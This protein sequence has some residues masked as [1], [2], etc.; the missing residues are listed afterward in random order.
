LN[1]AAVDAGYSYHTA[2]D[3]PERLTSAA[4]RTTGE[5]VV[6]I[7]TTL[8]RRD[9]TQRTRWGA[10]YFDVGG[11]SALSYGMI[12]SWIIAAVALM[13]G[14]V[15][16]LR[17]TSA[18]L[19]LSGTLRWIAAALWS[20]IGTAA[21]VASMVGTTWALRAGREVPPVVRAP[22][23]VVPVARGRRRDNRMGN[24]ARRR[25]AADGRA[26]PRHPVVIWS[27]ALPI[28]LVLAGAST[29]FTPAAAYL[30]TLPLLTAAILLVVAPLE[31]APVIRIASIVILAVAGTLWLR[32]TVDLLRFATAVLGRLPIVT[33]VYAYAAMMACAGLMVVPPLLAVTTREQPVS[34]PA[35]VTSV[36]L[37]ALAIAAGAA[38][39]AP[40]Y[41]SEY[42]AAA[43]RRA[44]QEPD[45]RTIWEV[46]AL[47]PGIDLGPGAPPGWTRQT[48]AAPRACHG[49]ASAI[50]RLPCHRHTARSSAGGSRRLLD[51][52][53][54]G[55]TEVALTIIPKRKSLAISFV[56]PAVRC[57]SPRR[58]PAPSGWDSGLRR[59]S[60]HRLKASRGG[61][62]QPRRRRAVA[63]LRV[64]VTDSGF[65]DGAGWQRLPGWLPQEHTVWT[66]PPPGW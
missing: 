36:C 31:Q 35:L 3:V 25:M 63:G 51:Q 13:L 40:A 30:W 19:R 47:E 41:T 22:G 1:F 28:W 43:T 46:T 16:W 17:A 59:S 44:L 33:P 38:A 56:L 10:T 54:R 58:S 39:L 14:V 11:V 6:A 2:R 32:N 57:H 26:R 48:N 34:R 61:D 20:V 29:W 42:A 24:D 60:R 12:V 27:L 66:P 23:S 53:F 50:L 9:I 15:A 4:L 8:D 55:G 64:A 52:A 7:A 49:D 5:N 65:S 18:A 37:L 45:N 62:L 21:V